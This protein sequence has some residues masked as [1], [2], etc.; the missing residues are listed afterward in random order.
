M[1]DMLKGLHPTD[2]DGL[3]RNALNEFKGCYWIGDINKDQRPV[4][5]GI[6]IDKVKKA[7]E[8]LEFAEDK[9]ITHK[10]IAPDQAK[11]LAQMYQGHKE[12][13]QV[14]KRWF[15]KDKNIGQDKNIQYGGRDI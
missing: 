6:R 12:F 8:I 5:I 9:I 11:E 14:L 15:E 1:Q 4:G 10:E 7:G 3:K 13:V 2:F